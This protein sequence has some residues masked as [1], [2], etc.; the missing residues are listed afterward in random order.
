VKGT[1][2]PMEDLIDKKEGKTAAAKKPSPTEK[3]TVESLMADHP[4]LVEQLKDRI[5]DFDMPDEV[6]V[7]AGEVKFRGKKLKIPAYTITRDERKEINVN[8]KFDEIPSKAVLK[9][10]SEVTGL[11]W[12]RGQGQWYGRK[13]CLLGT[14]FEL[15]A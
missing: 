2:T 15:Q 4:E 9:I 10:L 11:A 13:V 14:P 6:R 5:I 1:K 3:L 12:A 7:E 8:L